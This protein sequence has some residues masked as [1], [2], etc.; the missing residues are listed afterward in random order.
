MEPGLR[1]RGHL[2][3]A[4]AVRRH[5]RAAMEPGLRDR[6]HQQQATA[7]NNTAHKPQWSPV[8][9]TGVTSD[10]RVLRLD[11]NPAAAMEPG[12]RDRGHSSTCP[13]H[14]GG[15]WRRN[16][17]RSSRPGSRRP[18]GRGRSACSTPQWSPVFATGVT[19]SSGPAGATSGA[20]RNGARSSRPGSLDRIQRVA[21]VGVAAMEPG[22]RDRG[23]STRCSARSTRS[24]RNGAR[25][26]RPGSREHLA[27]GRVERE[28]AAMEPGLRDRG[29][30]RAPAWRPTG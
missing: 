21:D 27:A 30:C 11:L 26:S 8:F 28:P 13:R 7:R 23:H 5:R 17:A 4:P 2:R 20:C 19:P 15:P 1:D 9:A 24:R 22:L 25:S 14:T 6:G 18:P 10:G 3:G 12:L 29:H 16:G